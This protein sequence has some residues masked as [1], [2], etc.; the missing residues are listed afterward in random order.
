V[1]IAACLLSRRFLSRVTPRNLGFGSSDAKESWV[2]V[3]HIRIIFSNIYF[4]NNVVI[5]ASQKARVI[6]VGIV[7]FYFV[8]LETS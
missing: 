5:K 8:F 6:K 2:W 4:V 7:E 1:I 3:E